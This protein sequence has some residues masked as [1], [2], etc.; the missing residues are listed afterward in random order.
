MFSECFKICGLILAIQFLYLHIFPE[1]HVRPAFPEQEG[2]IPVSPVF[3]RPAE[4]KIPE[5]GCGTVPFHT[6]GK[7]QFIVFWLVQPVA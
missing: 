7:Q 3:Y 1:I 2:W 6:V 4:D 5:C